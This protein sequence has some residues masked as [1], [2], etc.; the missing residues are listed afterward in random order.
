MT[1]FYADDKV[2][3]KELNVMHE[4]GVLCHVVRTVERIARENHITRIK[5]IT[6]EVGDASGYVPYYLDKLF[7]HALQCCPE[8]GTPVLKLVNVTGNRLQIKDF[9]Y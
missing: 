9:G 2:F 5:Y 3:L 8:I 4:L 7:P 1:I 6:L